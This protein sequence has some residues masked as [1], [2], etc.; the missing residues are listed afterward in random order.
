MNEAA[1]KARVRA[2]TRDLDGQMSVRRVLPVPRHRSVGP[3]V[4]LDQMGPI[5]FAPGQGMDVG[6]HPHIGLATVTYLFEGAVTHRDSLGYDQVIRPGDVNWMTAGRGI[7]HSERTEPSMRAQGSN[8][9]GLQ[10]WVALPLA[11]EECEP[12][13]EHY[14]KAK[15]PTLQRD[16]FEVRVLAG[17]FEDLTSP[18]NFE[19][20]IAC[21]DVRT[22]DVGRLEVARTQPELAVYV[23]SGALEVGGE[24]YGGG[25]LAIFDEA[26]P[27][28]IRPLVRSRCWVFG[29]P[30]LDGPRYIQWNFVSSRIERIERA[31]EDWRLG[32]FVPVPGETERI[33]LPELPRLARGY[34]DAAT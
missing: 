8:L 27:I 24:R 22:P 2:R 26:G 1:V 29:G 14:P 17:A 19:G 25:D 33:P 20:D 23:A 16:D 32:R 28:I 5:P 10:A 18:V 12:R 31:K 30:P 13:F 9:F 15:L 21:Y 6:P 34:N 7:V 4:F 3:F 11:H